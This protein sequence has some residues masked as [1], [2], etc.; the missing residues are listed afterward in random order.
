MSEFPDQ[1][2]NKGKDFPKRAA[3]LFIFVE[4]IV[5]DLMEN[6]VFC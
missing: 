1:K 3:E 4:Q 6:D 5:K 2:S